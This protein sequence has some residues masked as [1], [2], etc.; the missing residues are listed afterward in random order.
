MRIVR[1]NSITEPV[2]CA[3]TGLVLAGDTIA[4]LRAGYAKYLL[5][6][7]RDVQGREIAALRIPADVRHIL[8]VGGPARAAIEAAAGWLAELQARIPDAC[9]VDGEPLFTPIS[10]ARLHNPLKPGR[11]IVVRG[12]ASGSADAPVV[13]NRAQASVMGPVRDIPLPATLQGL[14]YGTGIAIVI[15][16]RCH[17][18]SERDALACI[19]GYMVANEVEAFRTAG[20]GKLAGDMAFRRCIIGPH[21]VDAAD[22]GAV[23]SLRMTTRVNGDT[24]QTGSMDDLKVGIAPLIAALSAHALEPGDV[25]VTALLSDIAPPGGWTVPL[26]RAGDVLESEIETLGLMRNKVVIEGAHA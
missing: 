21:L 18:V 10:Q 24:C 26:L 3:R 11:L 17:A 23:E 25:I 15:G 16:K 2:S 6:E 19:G 12:N 13:W 4:D 9:G 14:A 7:A 8:H 5:E 1:F 20:A 22:V